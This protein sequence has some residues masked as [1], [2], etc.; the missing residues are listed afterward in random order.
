MKAG[1][2]K[3]LSPGGDADPSTFD[4]KL[5]MI[6][7]EFTIGALGNILSD[8]ICAKERFSAVKSM[9]KGQ[10]S[11]LL[12]NTAGSCKRGGHSGGLGILQKTA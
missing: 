4:A 7:E 12:Q 2:R 5:A 6:S 10:E 8:I 9:L 11:F 1:S 3:L